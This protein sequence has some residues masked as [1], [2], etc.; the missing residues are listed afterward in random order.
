MSHLLGL[1]GSPRR[2]GNTDALLDEALRGAIAGGASTE[3]IYVAQ[4]DIHPCRACNACARKGECIQKDDMTLLYEKLATADIL[5]VASPIFFY[6]VTAQLKSLIDRCQA[7]WN[8]KYTLAQPVRRGERGKGAFIAAGATGG[9][10]L[11]AGAI[12]TV[13]YFFDPL[14]VDY[15]AELTFRHLEERGA[16][17]KEPALLDKAYQLGYELAVTVEGVSTASVSQPLFRQ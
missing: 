2:N 13:K 15:T 5:L 4:L 9:Q 3:K 6:G 12:L 1:A 8:R 7:L 11:F 10:K 16:V 14:D 17:T